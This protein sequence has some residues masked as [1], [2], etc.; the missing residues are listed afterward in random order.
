MLKGLHTVLWLVTRGLLESAEESL[1]W[2]RGAGYEGAQLELAEMVNCTKT[3]VASNFQA[4]ASGS[5]LKPL[6]GSFPVNT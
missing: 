4:M 3:R 2:L 6:V 5:F 1:L